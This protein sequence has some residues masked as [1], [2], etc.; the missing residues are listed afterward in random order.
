MSQI[1]ALG[2]LHTNLQNQIKEKL[3]E[4]QFEEPYQLC[5][6]LELF[7][8][9]AAYKIHKVSVYG[10]MEICIVANTLP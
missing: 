1:T 10:W 3:L 8:D 6:H 5:Q 4:S 9:P 7:E 2:T